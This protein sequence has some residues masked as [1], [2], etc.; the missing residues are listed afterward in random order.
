MNEHKAVAPKMFFSL[1]AIRGLAALSVVVYHW[2]HFFY[3]GTVLSNYD[4]L[5]QPFYSFLFVFYKKGYFSIDLFFL[6]SGFIF[7]LLYSN[8]IS[9]KE[10]SIRSFSILRFSRLY[11]L[12]FITLLFVLAIQMVTHYRTGSF[13]VHPLNDL[14]HFILNV[15]LASGLGLEHGSSFNSPVWSVSIEVLLYAIFFILCSFGKSRPLKLLIFIFTGLVLSYTRFPLTVIGKGI[16]SFFLG[17]LVFHYYSNIIKAEKYYRFLAPFAIVLFSVWVVT[18]LEI[19][20]DFIE[21]IFLKL[22]GSSFVFN[23]YDYSTEIVH[24]SFNLFTTAF[25][26]PLTILLF[27]LI[28]TYRGHLGRRVSFLGK[29]SYSV[30]LLHF[31][32]QL[33]II[34]LTGILGVEST[35]F[36]TKTSMIL[37]FFVLIPLSLSSYRFFERPAQELIRSKLLARTIRDMPVRKQMEE[38]FQEG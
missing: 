5:A 6:L 32:L 30:Y 18:F 14:Y 34:V 28:E 16:F 10:I 26:F 17:G 31:P 27:A 33:I 9:A 1:D 11:P 7:F 12:H 21:S 19:K 20:F 25:L 15:F 8:R 29:I 36:Y 38:R 13:I 2:K 35:F 4:N 37:F 24:Q 23:S 3:N 22:L